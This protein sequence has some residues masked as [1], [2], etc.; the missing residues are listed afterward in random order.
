MRSGTKGTADCVITPFVLKGSD[1]GDSVSTTEYR[2]HRED[3]R[4]TWNDYGYLSV[5][6]DLCP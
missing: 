5:A 6:K 1:R 2:V 4:G 3:K